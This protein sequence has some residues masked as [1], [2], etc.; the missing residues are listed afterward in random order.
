MT[1][2]IGAQWIVGAEQNPLISLLNL[3][4][5]RRA[6]E[7]RTIVPKVLDTLINQSTCRDGNNTMPSHC[8]SRGC[9]YDDVSLGALENLV[10]YLSSQLHASN[11]LCS[12]TVKLNAKVTK[13]IT[14]EQRSTIL[15]EEGESFDASY[16]I[17]T[18]PAGVL[19]ALPVFFEP[20]LPQPINIAIQNLDVRR[21]SV[22]YLSFASQL[23]QL[24]EAY[25]TVDT[26]ASH[27]FDIVNLQM[28]TGE[29]VIAT[30]AD[31]DLSIFL[32]QKTDEET[33]EYILRAIQKHFGIQ[34]SVVDHL[35]THW[36]LHPNIRGS[37]TKPSICSKSFDIATLRQPINGRMIFAGE[38]VSSVAPGSLH[39]AFISGSE[40][41][42]KIV[43]A[44]YE[45]HD[46]TCDEAQECSDVVSNVPDAPF[47]E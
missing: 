9:T 41:A 2:E 40:Q 24:N 18:I 11:G 8:I 27:S 14:N 37:Y 43:E 33:V 3:A 44:L 23:E 42:F 22:V 39:G 16:V 12:P 28:Y 31:H 17:S 4:N 32:E 7:Y 15:T 34:L 10:S 25:Y 1:I 36:G 47:M 6:K 46:M 21:T 13:I 26:E 20:P 30:Y 38:W 5:V 45:N 35:V 19:Q 29:N